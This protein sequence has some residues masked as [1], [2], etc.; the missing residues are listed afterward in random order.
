M[1]NEPKSS[2]GPGR[3]STHITERLRVGAWYWA[4]RARGW[5]NG[6]LD[7]KFGHPQSAVPPAY[8][9]RNRIFERIQRTYCTPALNLILRVDA[10]PDFHGTAQIYNSPFWELIICGP[11]TYLDAVIFVTKCLAQTGMRRITESEDWQVRHDDP[12]LSKTESPALQSRMLRIYIASFLRS[13]LDGRETTLDI[14]ALVGGLYRE[15]YLACALDVAAAYKD[16][17]I[18]L[19]EEFFDT[20]DWLSPIA[21]DLMNCA[22]FR[23]IYWNIPEDVGTWESLEWPAFS[24]ERPI[25][26]T[27]D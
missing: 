5:K 1:S 25:V 12:Y 20:Q 2:A 3:K 19:L 4:V 21:S 6:K 22:E 9:D 27:S 15:A 10:H 17:Y 24:T 16:A 7:L 23:A 13:A 8:V 26:R 11:T 14:L 18:P